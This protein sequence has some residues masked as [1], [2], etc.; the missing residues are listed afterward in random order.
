M[1]QWVWELV[2][3]KYS[4]II[5]QFVFIFWSIEW[6]GAAQTVLYSLETFFFRIEREK[7]DMITLMLPCKDIFNFQMFFTHHKAGKYEQIKCKSCILFCKVDIYKNY[8]I[9]SLEKANGIYFLV[10]SIF[11]DVTFFGGDQ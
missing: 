5:Q 11:L 9:S 2:R 3:E 7:R 10:I 8:R 1:K 6:S 4:Y